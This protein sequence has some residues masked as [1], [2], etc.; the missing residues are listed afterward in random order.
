M[1]TPLITVTRNTQ[2]YQLYVT[3]TT[4]GF[5]PRYREAIGDLET[6]GARRQDN[7]RRWT[8]RVALEPRLRQ[9]IDNQVAKGWLVEWADEH[10]G[11]NA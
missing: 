10:R 4:V 9:W 5:V 8:V 1:N 6:L 11:N 2:G 7:G 3:V